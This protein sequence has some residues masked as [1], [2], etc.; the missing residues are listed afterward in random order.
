MKN[1]GESGRRISLDRLTLARMGIFVKQ[2]DGT[3]EIAN[4]FWSE[5][6]YSREEMAGDRWIEVIHPDDREK[7]LEFS[8]HLHDET[9]E[10]ERVVYRIRTRDGDWRWCMTSGMIEVN[11]ET[12]QRLLIGHDQ[13]ITYIKEL[14]QNAED[15]RTEAERRAQEA[16]TL[17]HAGAIIT[18]S[19]DRQEMVTRV[20]DQLRR[21]IPI[22]HCLVFERHGRE[23][24]ALFNGD[25]HEDTPIALFESEPG[26]D[27]IVKSLR[28]G[29][30]GVFPDPEVSS[31]H[32]LVV[33][34]MIRGEPEGVCVVGRADDRE[35]TARD[36]HNALAVS[37]YLAVALNNGRLFEG[38]TTLATTDPLSGLLNRRAFFIEAR[39]VLSEIWRD[40]APVACFVADIDHFKSINDEYGHLIGDEVIRKIA[41]SMRNALRDEDYVGRYGGE[42]FVALLPGVPLEEARKV[43]DRVRV[44]I[45]SLDVTPV[46]RSITCSVGVTALLTMG[47]E[48]CPNLDSLLLAAD[49]ALYEAKN[50][51]RNRV[52]AIRL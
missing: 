6:G 25:H 14:Q 33:P 46:E 10:H 38:M 30:P 24:N 4:R 51:G 47:L 18:A 28:E 41:S 43:A 36:I 35:F 11:Q 34:L 16:D 2:F 40:G 19:L 3:V 29:L 17:R 20:V 21:L 5:L 49:N 22:E 50:G 37:D 42:E 48:A 12:G 23:L 52:E 9:R 8:R 45:S 44:H 1:G 13:D 7:A 32:W 15:A 27:W 39:Q 26:H 31:R